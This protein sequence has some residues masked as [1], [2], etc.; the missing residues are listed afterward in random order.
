NI[1]PEPKNGKRPEWPTDG[2]LWWHWLYFPY[3]GSKEKLR[4]VPGS[5][6][7]GKENRPFPKKLESLQD[8]GGRRKRCWRPAPFPPPSNL[9]TRL[10]PVSSLAPSSPCFLPLISTQKKNFLPRLSWGR[11]GSFSKPVEEGQS[12]GHLTDV[13]NR[14]PRQTLH[15]LNRLACG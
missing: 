1:L 8:H 6:K 10:R 14:L 13:F 5:Q 11:K 7:L 15:H 4:Y 12:P 3:G 9:K 2:D